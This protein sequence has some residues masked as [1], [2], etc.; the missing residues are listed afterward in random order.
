VA[1][2]TSD[3]LECE[4][5]CAGVGQEDLGFCVSVSVFLLYGAVVSVGGVSQ[6]SLGAGGWLLIRIYTLVVDT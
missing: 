3:T 1:G 2:G 6:A 4:T 5:S